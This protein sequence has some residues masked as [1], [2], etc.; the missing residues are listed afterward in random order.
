MKSLQMLKKL[1]QNSK[2]LEKLKNTI[3]FEKEIEKNAKRLEF[4]VSKMSENL[5]TIFSLENEDSNQ[6]I[7]QAI[8]E[9]LLNC[10]FKKTVFK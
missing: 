1:V 8:F 10:N 7:E 2:I 4:I 5:I 9:T 6:D 3:M